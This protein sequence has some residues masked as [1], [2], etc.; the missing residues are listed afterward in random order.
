MKFEIHVIGPHSEGKTNLLNWLSGSCEQ[1]SSDIPL[2]T[3]QFSS[4]QWSS[5]YYEIKQQQF[6]SCYVNSLIDNAVSILSNGTVDKVTIT[7]NISTLTN[8]NMF[9]AFIWNMIGYSECRALM[10]FLSA[11]PVTIVTFDVPQQLGEQLSLATSEELRRVLENIDSNVEHGSPLIVIMIGIHNGVNSTILDQCRNNILDYIN[12]KSY[13]HY[14]QLLAVNP[15]Q[16]VMF[17][18]YQCEDS[19]EVKQ[20]IIDRVE[21]YHCAG[22]TQLLS[23]DHCNMLQYVSDK[24]IVVMNKK[25]FSCTVLPQS[26]RSIEQLSADGVVCHFDRC[27]PSLQEVIFTSPH[28]LNNMIMLLTSP[29]GWA[30]IRVSV[31]SCCN[32]VISVQLLDLLLQ[33]YN[34]S[35]VKLTQVMM[36]LLVHLNLAVPLSS[37]VITEAI[38]VSSDEATALLVPS[39]ISSDS[40]VVTSTATLIDH[41]AIILF[42]TTTTATGLVSYSTTQLLVKLLTWGFSKGHHLIRSVFVSVSV[43]VFIECVCVFVRVCILSVCVFIVCVCVCICVCVHACVHACMHACEVAVCVFMCVRAHVC[44]HP[45]MHACEVAVCVFIVCVCVCVCVRTC[46]CMHACGVAVCVC[47]CVCARALHACMHACGVAV[48]VCVCVCVCRLC[49]IV[50]WLLPQLSW[51]SYI[52]YSRNI[53]YAL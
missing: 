49:C 50:K 34:T 48:C 3:I 53:P 28:W 12:A 19:C 11:K 14:R 39:L 35:T 18:D 8:H 24:A 43:C 16:A 2:V 5:E 26:K 30:T 41:T 22:S 9:T 31:D 15:K 32:G 37:D 45:C 27:P 25:Q 20:L 36:S 4:S 40:S 1:S 23:T 33:S 52:Q 10:R 21:E 6:V 7:D 44:V 42:T 13:R 51:N 29:V 38:L 17:F 47:V 46:A